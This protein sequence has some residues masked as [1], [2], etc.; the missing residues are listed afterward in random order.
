MRKIL[1]PLVVLLLMLT[2]AWFVLGADAPR[3][4]EHAEAG[5]SRTPVTAVDRRA[6]AEEP[7]AEVR[8]KEARAKLS[9]AEREALRGRIL[10]ALD[11][12]GDAAGERAARAEDEASGAAGRRAKKGGGAG[13]GD[14]PSPGGLVDRTGN[15]PHLVK[16]MNEDLMPLVDECYA[17]ART[18]KPD[19]AGLLVLDVEMLGD[20]EIGGVVES[21][22]PGKDN[23]LTEPGLVECVRESLLS[24]SLPPPPSGGRDE[25]QMQLRLTPDEE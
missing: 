11:A 23:E 12:R 18:R 16:V 15:H 24:T 20:A 22:A 21:I 13:V 25:I 7:P 4:A 9:K 8:Q 19:L 1:V 10:A 5:G 3:T 2:G 14:A 6:S 17:M